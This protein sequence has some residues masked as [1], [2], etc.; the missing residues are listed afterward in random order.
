M[1]LGGGHPGGSDRPPAGRRRPLQ[2]ARSPPGPGPGGA[3]EALYRSRERVR[4]STAVM[5]Q[6][7][8]DET[9]L[10]EAFEA[11][12]DRAPDA[13]AVAWRDQR[14]TYRQLDERANRLAAHLRALGVGPEVRVGVCMERSADLIVALLATL[15]AGGAYVPLDP[16]YPPQRV[17]YMLD[18]SRAEVVLTQRSVSEVLPPAG[19]RS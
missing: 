5:M 13:L 12:V 9:L 16:A 8:D 1:G 7:C 19:D 11:W 2:D 3:S 15:K 18:D 6:P 14:L 17:A 4:W 10:H